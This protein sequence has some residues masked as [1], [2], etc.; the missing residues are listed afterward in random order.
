[1][2]VAGKAI[3]EVWYQKWSFHLRHRP[4]SG[5]IVYLQK[6]PRLQRALP[7]LADKG[8]RHHRDHYQ[9]VSTRS[10]PHAVMM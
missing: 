7:R 6:R 9:P 5:A 3:R 2:T 1:V 4:E 8:G 10:L